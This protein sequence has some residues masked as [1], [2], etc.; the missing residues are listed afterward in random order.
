[1]QQS[2]VNFN[3]QEEKQRVL[4][5]FALVVSGER[6]LDEISVES[7]KNVMSMEEIALFF[8]LL[9]KHFNSKVKDTK[10]EKIK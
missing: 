4:N 2:F 10:T 9:A 8:E 3:T 1:M 5:L 6:N 7:L